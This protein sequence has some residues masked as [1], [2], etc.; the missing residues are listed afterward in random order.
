MSLVYSLVVM[1]GLM[2]SALFA[3]LPWL[4]E[5]TPLNVSEWSLLISGSMFGFVL[6]APWWGRVTDK[7]GAKYTLL[8]TFGGFTLANVLLVLAISPW[9]LEVMTL[10][11]LLG[12]LILSRIIYATFTAGIFGAAQAWMLLHIEAHET[13]TALAKL[14]AVNQLGRMIGPLVVMLGAFWYPTLALYVFVV[15]SALMCIR[16]FLQRNRLAAGPN[17]VSEDKPQEVKNNSQGSQKESLTRDS[18]QRF[19]LMK[20]LPELLMAASL[21]LSVGTLQFSLGPYLQWL[22]QLSA[23]EATTEV[24]QLLFLSAFVVTL[25]ALGLV[26]RIAH[27]T[28]LYLGMMLLGLLLGSSLLILAE[29]KLLWC[30]A[31]ALMSMGVALGSP[32]YGHLLRERWPEDQGRIGGYLTSAHTIGYGSGTLIAG[33]LLQWQPAWALYPVVLTGMH[34]LLF[35]L[36][37]GRKS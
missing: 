37:K 15:L 32:W 18:G 28:K 8:W 19:S 24:S 11:V 23:E 21:T 27:L 7:Y 30:L 9:G 34:I 33:G 3:C 16:L 10:S 4:I 2:Q 1:M 36:I 20:A 35:L 22:W 26:P 12:V 5:Y 13:R 6:I 14:N 29:T 25:V 17:A 31:I